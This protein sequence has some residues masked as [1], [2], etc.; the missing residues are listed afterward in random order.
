MQEGALIA[1][2]VNFST[3]ASASLRNRHGGP[4]DLTPICIEPDTVDPLH[5][6]N[7]SFEDLFIGPFTQEG[8]PGSTHE[9]GR[10]IP[11]GGSPPGEN[12]RGPDRSE[13]LQGLLAGN[14]ETEAIRLETA[15]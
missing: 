13:Y 3:M 5:V 7:R 6:R 2:G 10:Q 9:Y 4:S 11:S 14:E 15:L 12:G 1:E 8:I